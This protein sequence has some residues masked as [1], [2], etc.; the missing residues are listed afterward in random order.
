[1]TPIGCLIGAETR[2]LLLGLWIKPDDWKA[3]KAKPGCHWLL[4]FFA[5]CCW[6]TLE[7]SLILSMRRNKALAVHMW[8]ALI[9][10]FRRTA[11]ETVRFSLGPHTCSF[12]IFLSFSFFCR[13]AKFRFLFKNTDRIVTNPILLRTTERR[14]F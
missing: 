5:V 9:P 12:I 10:Y 8:F 2:E 4:L 11:E 1:M 7:G 3:W 6:F 13:R 14:A